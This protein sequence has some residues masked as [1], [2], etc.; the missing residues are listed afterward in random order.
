[1]NSDSENEDE[2]RIPSD[3]SSEHTPESYTQIT[4]SK[5]LLLRIGIIGLLSILG[6]AGFAIFSSLQSDNRIANS[7]RACEAVEASGITVAENGLSVSFD[8]K[9][10]EDFFG[11][12]YFDLVCIVNE[13]NAPS[14]VPERF[15]RTN[16][17]MGV[18]NAE[19][20]GISITW[21][22]HPNNGLDADIVII[23]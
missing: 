4:I 5:S 3:N 9:G 20:D 12:D 22:Y 21:S 19:W 16:A 6:I 18:Q 1:M 7:L 13:L 8:G 14:T 23:K 15:G 10:E 11:G 17:L 2:K